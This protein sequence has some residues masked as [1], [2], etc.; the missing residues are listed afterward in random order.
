MDKKG[1]VTTSIIGGIATV[2]FMH[3][4]SNSLPLL[5]TRKITDSIN[6]FA[7]DKHAHVIIIR[8]EGEKAFCAGASFDEL[9]QIKD[10]KSGKK[11][12]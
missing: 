6:K 5:L 11:F 1:I 3:P 12:F 10:F 2:S 7:E 4:K 9:L 8:S